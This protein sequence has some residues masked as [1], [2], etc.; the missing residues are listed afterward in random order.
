G[1][2]RAARGQRRGD[3]TIAFAVGAVAGHASHHIDVAPHRDALGMLPG[4]VWA[5]MAGE[6]VLIGHDRPAVLH[7]QLPLPRRHGRALA[8]ERFDLAAFA[9]PP[10]PVVLTPLSH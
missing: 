10:E 3:R 8:L 7:G 1:L 9:D 5:L 6:R 2:G 4:H